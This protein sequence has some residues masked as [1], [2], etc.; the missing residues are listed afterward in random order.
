M[1]YKVTPTA[2]TEQRMSEDEFD[3]L[4]DIFEGVDWDDISRVIPSLSFS[5]ETVSRG[6]TGID[7]SHRGV[8]S[9][10]VQSPVDSAPPIDVPSSPDEYP[11]DEVDQVF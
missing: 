5:C 3:A 8:S 2:A 7:L 1:V 11:F 6:D 4:P 10:A 9:Q